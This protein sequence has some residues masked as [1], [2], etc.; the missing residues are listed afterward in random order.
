MHNIFYI[1]PPRESGQRFA[2]CLELELPILLNTM[3]AKFNVEST[4]ASQAKAPIAP[5]LN[6]SARPSRKSFRTYCKKSESWNF[7]FFSTT[8][9]VR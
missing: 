1:A 8:V 7:K 9:V 5:Q 3:R 6:C 4:L 2:R